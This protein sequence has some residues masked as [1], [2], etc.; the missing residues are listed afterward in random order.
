MPESWLLSGRSE[1]RLAPCAGPSG[2]CPAVCTQAEGSSRH[3]RS[4]LQRPAVLVA[5]SASLAAQRLTLSIVACV[6]G[7]C[8]SV[9]KQQ[10]PPGLPAHY[11]LPS[12]TK[13]TSTSPHHTRDSV[14]CSESTCGA[15]TAPRCAQQRQAARRPWSCRTSA[16]ASWARACPPGTCAPSPAAAPPPGERSTT[17][18][19]GAQ[20]IRASL[21]ATRTRPLALQRSSASAAAA[22]SCQ[23]PGSLAG[24]HTL[25]PVRFPAAPSHQ[26]AASTLS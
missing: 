14:T 16:G 11:L 18:P 10:A 8:M 3:P 9:R 21:A 20:Y 19:S 12:R 15:V 22:S 26:P 2:L 23:A 1:R 17:P 7:Q 4:V 5:Q 25:A 6:T 24:T 13:A